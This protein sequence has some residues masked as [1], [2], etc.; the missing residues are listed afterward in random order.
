MPIQ[1]DD[2]DSAHEEIQDLEFPRGI[3]SDGRSVE[4]SGRECRN[5]VNKVFELAREQIA[6]RK[7]EG[8]PVDEEELL[9]HYLSA[10]LAH[11]VCM[12]VQEAAAT[13]N[14]CLSRDLD[15]EA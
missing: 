6:F 11:A 9:K 13:M 10:V 15:Y 7:E 5:Q 12:G 3:S 8:E 4:V 14:L 1:L 2:D